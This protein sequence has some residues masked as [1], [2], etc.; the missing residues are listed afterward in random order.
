MNAVNLFELEQMSKSIMY[1]ILKGELSWEDEK[2]QYY[3][4]LAFAFTNYDWLKYAAENILIEEDCKIV[5][6]FLDSVKSICEVNEKQLTESME[7]SLKR[8]LGEL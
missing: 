8:K 4:P 5:K 7:E 3:L 6:N 1:D 2:V